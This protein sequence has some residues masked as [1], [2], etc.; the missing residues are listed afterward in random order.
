MRSSFCDFHYL[1]YFPRGFHVS[2]CQPEEMLEPFWEQN[3]L[4]ISES[5]GM[6]SPGTQRVVFEIKFPYGDTVQVRRFHVFILIFFIPCLLFD[7]S[8]HV[9]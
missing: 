1:G 6:S 2:N 8:F 4:Y 5:N 9:A 3:F 7:S